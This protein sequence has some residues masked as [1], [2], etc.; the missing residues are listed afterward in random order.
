[1]ERELY[2][3]GREKARQGDYTGAIAD[4]TELLQLAPYRADVYYQRG[5]AYYDDTQLHN[6]V[7][8]YTRAIELNP[9][10][11]EAYAAR[12]LV[13][14]A[15]KNGVGALEDIDRALR[16]DDK[17]A[18]AHNLRGIACRKLGDNVGAI[19]SFKTAAEL[20]LA[21]K[22]ADNCRRCLERAK[23]LQPKLSEPVPQPKLTPV[24]LMSPGEIY[25]QILE[26]VEKGDCRGAIQELN[27]AIDLDAGDAAAYCCRGIARSKLGDD[28]G[29]I[30]DF[31]Q[32]IRL[33]PQ[34]TIAR[35]NRGKIRSKLGDW[36][37]AIADFNQAIET[38]P[39][40]VLLLLARGNAYREMGNYT[41]AIDD[42][43]QALTLDSDRSEAYMHRALAYL[44]LEELKKAI[45][46]Y[47][48]A[49]S[50]YCETEDWENYQK[51]LDALKQLQSAVPPSSR[52]DVQSNPLQQRLLML[53]GGQWALAE[54]L[55]EQAKYYYPNMDEDWYLEK[56]IY[57]LERD[58]GNE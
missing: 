57:D 1:M 35:R 32:A 48:T 44:R 31:N 25:A 9:D 12:A 23:Q 36:G 39:E 8:D 50:R 19:A 38:E 40:D 22:D 16:F 53:V 46:D 26:Q 30:A 29:A 34:D 56:V 18:S 13:R 21:L 3:R 37:G 54:R 47:Q 58:R 10:Y 7:S 33:N 28:R 14:L 15:L 51:A 27:W 5:L 49:A 4:F 42:Y 2:D 20:Y 45:D 6:A 52:K 43:T 11:R 55:I 41:G 24:K 17:D